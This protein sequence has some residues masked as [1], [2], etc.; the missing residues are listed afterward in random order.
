MNDID[1]KYVLKKAIK[2]EPERPR[3]STNCNYVYIDNDPDDGSPRY[4]VCSDAQIQNQFVPL[5]VREQQIAEAVASFT[6]AFC[7]AR[8][9]EYFEDSELQS[10]V[11]GVLVAAI[12]D[13][14]REK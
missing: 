3:Y 5:S 2:I 13:I 10:N 9:I 1:D 6:K 11:E 12:L 4:I 14:E 8:G 7:Q